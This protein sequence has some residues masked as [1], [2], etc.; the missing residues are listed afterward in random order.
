MAIYSPIWKD[1]F[2]ETTADTLSYYIKIEDEYADSGGD[3]IFRG[4][5]IK[6]PN[7]DTL[8]INI[9]KICQNHL[10]QNDPFGAKKEPEIVEDWE[11]ITENFDR[12][13]EISKIQF[14]IRLIGDYRRD[15]GMFSESPNINLDRQS[16]ET[17][18]TADKGFGT[19]HK[20]NTTIFNSGDWGE[21]YN[22][23]THSSNNPIVITHLPDK[24]V[25]DLA[26]YYELDL[27]GHT[28]YWGGAESPE[29]FY[30]TYRV[31]IKVLTKHPKPVSWTKKHPNAFTEFRLYKDDGTLLEVY[32][33]LY[34]WSYT[35]WEG[36]TGYKRLS[37]PINNKYAPNQYV[38][39]TYYLDR[40]VQTEGD[41]TEPTTCA[42]YALYYC[43]S[44][45]GWDSYAL[46]GFVKKTDNVTEHSYNKSFDNTTINFERGR[47]ISEIETSYE[48][49]TSWLTDKQAEI[50]TK[51][52]LESNMVY[53]HNLK[54]DKIIP[55]IITTTECA[56]K[57]HKT[58]RG[59]VS[60]VFNITESQSKQRR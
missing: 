45:G 15:W 43:N 40:E 10:A 20:F 19:Y 49:H 56:Y 46:D 7:A 13:K 22:D 47:Y 30:D 24:G 35:E 41:F 29:Y 2:Y 26:H 60:Y 34:D 4:K 51:E 17:S 52:L 50:F 28:L 39:N 55:V 8:R 44:H 53:L 32:Y 37:N 16:K 5:A 27:S 59:L 58:E 42:D 1:I 48:I 31:R 9:N 6:M 12:T 57:T 14:G 36:G 25:E 33:L 54:E 38:L 3:V 23:F 21:L 18:T 11:L